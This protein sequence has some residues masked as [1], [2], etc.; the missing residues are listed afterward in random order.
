FVDL[1]RHYFAWPD[2]EE[3][4]GR[5]ARIAAALQ[6]SALPATR[7]GEI[8]PLLADLFSLRW[9][10]E[11]SD[12]RGDDLRLKNTDP[13]QRRQQT[14]LAVRD[15]FLALTRQRPLVLVLEDLH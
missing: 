1:L 6:E 15:F 4:A 5:V 14:F 3:D 10:Q 8:G 2:D 7:A 12:A 9:G 11:R 13:E